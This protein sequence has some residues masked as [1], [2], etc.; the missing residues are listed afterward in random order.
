[1][2]VSLNLENTGIRPYNEGHPVVGVLVTDGTPSNSEKTQ[3]FANIVSSQ[4]FL[5]T[6]NK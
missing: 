2:P 6:K 3:E 4:G 1:M 5:S